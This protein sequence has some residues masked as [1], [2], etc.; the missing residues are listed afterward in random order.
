[1][2][3]KVPTD[4]WKTLFDEVYLIT[5]ARS[6][7]DDALTAR[8]VDLICR[9]IPIQPSQNILDLCGGHGRHSLELC[10]RGFAHCTVFDFSR[11]LLQIGARQ[12]SQSNLSVEFVQGDAR[13][14]PLP[15]AGYHH[16][17]I[18]GNSLGYA[19]ESGAD[20]E[21]MGEAHRLLTQGG[22]ILVDVAD[23]RAVQEHFKPSAWHEIGD[24]VVVCRQRELQTGV[25]YARELVLNKDSGLIRDESYRMQ[26]YTSEELVGLVSAAGFGNVHLRKDFSRHH[27][28]GDLGFMNH[29]MVVTAQKP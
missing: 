20:R 23:G 29:R 4:W 1:M 19:G 15:S 3:I 18:L 17:L 22:W 13:D 10:R 26:L 7:C 28:H 21:I 14:I 16:V 11:T 6:V 8:E 27:G 2:S 25:I 12:A 9:L 5:D 24:D